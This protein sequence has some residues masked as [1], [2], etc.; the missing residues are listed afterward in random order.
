MEL[1]KH[2]CDEESQVPAFSHAAQSKQLT[3]A[4]GGTSSG[5][6]MILSMADLAHKM[7]VQNIDDF[8][9]VPCITMY[10]NWFMQFGDNE[11]AKGDM[12]VQALGTIGVMK[13]ELMAQRLTQLITQTSNPVD[14]QL[15]NRQQLW[16]DT[17]DAFDLDPKKYMTQGMPGAP[18]GA[19]PPP[20][21]G[22]PMTMV[23]PGTPTGP[24]PQPMPQEVPNVAKAQQG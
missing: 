4:T 22:Q 19:P 6:A 7:A 8:F 16:L 9:T 13:K 12:Q 3:A 2:Q 17:L 15:M 23:A 5:M 10:Y 18:A 11:E 1:A 14:A 21:P 24:G 20:A